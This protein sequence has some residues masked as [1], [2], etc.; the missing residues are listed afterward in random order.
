MA[1]STDHP[2][3]LVEPKSVELGKVSYVFIVVLFFASGA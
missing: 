1:H 2:D 3:I